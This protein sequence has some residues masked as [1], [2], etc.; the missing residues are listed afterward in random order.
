LP[1]DVSRPNQRSIPRLLNGG[2]I[3]RTIPIEATNRR[4]G[5][6]IIGDAS[7]AN[8][9]GAY[10]FLLTENTLEGGEIAAWL[11]TPGSSSSEWA[12][13]YQATISS[14]EATRSE[15]RFSITTI[16]DEL[17]RALQLRQYTG[18]GGTAG[19]AAV[20]GRLKPIALGEIFG[21]NPILINTADRVYAVHDGP[22]QSIDWVREGGLDYTFTADYP[23]YE[24]L[25]AATLASGE[26]A[27]C[28]AEGI[29]RIGTT[30]AGLVYPLRVG[31]QGDRSGNGYVNDTGEILYRLA[32][33]RAFVSPNNLDLA[34]FQGLPAQAVGYY[35]DGSTNIR[36]SDVFNA[37]LGGVVGYYGVGRGNQITV[38][39]VLPAS[40]Q[41]NAATVREEQIITDRVEARPD[42]LRISQPY[43]YA[44]TWAPLTPEQISP[45]ANADVAQRLQEPYQSDE[46][47]QESDLAIKPKQNPVLNTFFAEQ[48]PA[49]QSA[50]D[51]LLIA[52]QSNLPVRA[53]IGR[54]GL[55]VDIGQ[56]IGIESDRW[57][58]DYRGVIYEQE[59]DLGAV[60][61]TR[62]TA[63]G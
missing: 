62:V 36:V 35:F 38:G 15:I 6:R 44:P 48:S 9:D 46:A 18:S 26:Y 30:L 19:D 54:L 50:E 43:T 32:S 52:S 57:G 39:Q 53:D 2:R 23:D 17:D 3:T 5:Q 28:L 14:V 11:A 21:A 22:I 61:N 13:I 10:D 47:F 56:V 29:F 25:A 60:V 31:L 12:L 20:K 33:S 59:D 24:T 51:A 37:L 16:A 4:R 58:A 1:T 49:E 8:A 40:F 45:S 55:Q 42:E 27:T 34:A 41:T 63:I 7:I